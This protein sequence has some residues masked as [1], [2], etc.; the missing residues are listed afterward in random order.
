MA[1][2]QASECGRA[3]CKQGARSRGHYAAINNR[4][5]SA[6]NGGNMDA[7]LETIKR[8]VSKMNIVNLSTALHRLAKLAARSARALEQVK[9]HAVVDQLVAAVSAL[10]TI[11]APRT[12]TVPQPQALSNIVW[13]LATIQRMDLP[14]LE[15]CANLAQMHF[16]SFKPYELSAVLWAF[17]TYDSLDSTAASY[18]APLFRE[19]A[20]KLPGN[21]QDYSFR[22]LVMIVWAFATAGHHDEKLFASAAQ[23]MRVVGESANRQDVSNAAWAFSRAGFFHDELFEVLSRKW[24]SQCPIVQKRP[25]TP[26]SDCSTSSIAAGLND[27]SSVTSEEVTGLGG[28]PGL[29]P[30]LEFMPQSIDLEN[31]NE[32]R[33]QYRRYRVGHANGSK[34]EIAPAVTIHEEAPCIQ[35]KPLAPP[36]EFIPKTVADDELSVFRRDYQHFREGYAKGAKGEL[37]EPKYIR[38]EELSCRPL[39]AK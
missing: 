5:I 11:S 24:P 16:S 22:C 32:W 17:A 7:L 8:D 14:L 33:M 12:D 19:A 26:P 28:P 2:M 38:L 29:P 27:I 9:T 39:H 23:Q 15:S 34:G 20:D 18:G 31:L 30:P 3:K 37:P 36:L 10:R 13:A 35:D 21:M 4:L 6:A 25:E 1:N